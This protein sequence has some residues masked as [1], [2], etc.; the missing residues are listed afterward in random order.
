LIIWVDAQ[1]S[2][3]LAPW[4]TKQF[5]IDAASLRY[6][7]SVRAIDSDIFNAARNAGAVVMTKDADFVVLL[8]RFGPP[9]H[10]LWVRCGN[11]SNARMREVLIETLPSS[12]SLIEAGEALVEI[13]DIPKRRPTILTS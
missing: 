1:L 2:P 5:G 3:A 10:V 8:E 7:G 9:P 4:I 6:L 12:L 13:T 11:T